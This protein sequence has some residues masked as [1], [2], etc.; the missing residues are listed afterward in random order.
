MKNPTLQ[1]MGA[2]LLVLCTGTVFAA[3]LGSGIDRSTFDAGVRPQDDLFLSATGQ[4][5]KNTPIPADK[6]AYGVFQELADRADARVR[7]ICEE[8]SQG[9][10]A[11][12]S[13][14]QKVGSYY[15]SYIDVDAIDAAG[16]SP[17]APWLA[18]IDAVTTPTE[19]VVLWGRWQGV[20]DS[21]MV[22]AVGGDPKQPTINRVMAI[23]S[24]LGL[25]DRD[26][27]LKRDPNFAKARAAYLAYMETLLQLSG[28]AQA[29]QHAKAVMALETELARVQWSVVDSQDAIKTFNPMT[30]PVLARRA[31]G[32]DWV[33]FFRA[34]ALPEIDRLSVQQPSYARAM[35]R[36]AQRTPMDTWRWYERVRLMDAQAAV[37]PKAWR[38]AAFALRGR[39]LRGQ[40][41][42]KPRWQ[43]ATDA[44]DAALGEAVGQV[45]V[46]RHFSPEAKARMQEMV[47]NLFAAFGQ[48]IDR[49]SWMTPATRQRAQEKL[50]KYT[51]KIGYPDKWRDYSA[52]DVRDGDAFGNAARA[53]RFEHERRAVQVGQ[54][55]DRSEWG[56]TPQTVNAYYD[57]SVNEIVFPAAILDTPLF[58]MGFDDAANYGA[59][60][61]TIGHEI[62]HGFDNQGSQYDGNGKLQNWWTAADRKAFDA[63]GARLVKQFNGYESLPGHK[64]N[65][66]LTLGE[67]IADL[68]GLEIAYKA[69]HLS[70]KG[71]PAPV[72]DG[73]TG[74]QRFFLAW[75]A[76]GR[77]K[78]RDARALELVTADPHAPARFRANGAVINLDAFHA[79]FGTQPGD[80]MYKPG[81]QR[82]RIW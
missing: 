70:L 81:E 64:V 18:Q 72:I 28:D 35:A 75:A 44:V 39:T 60:G 76:S 14:E 24:G 82:I 47:A 57:P 17:L 74:D 58:D 2:A 5:V 27:Y 32:L 61:A 3:S 19:L 78:M 46:A 7:K 1:R 52:L 54:P 66:R 45:Y 22:V 65:G 34:A 73:L 43:K 55:V 71:Q 63:L 25:P 4:W 48:S 33:A 79:T 38:H 11:K 40:E 30:M 50:A 23:Q 13:I 36:L 49:L 8:L 15:R 53:G 67:N 29:A 31:P 77:E 9:E 42:D 6:P 56:M 68:S 80:R 37:L 59:T 12:G 10:A 69:Y 26:Y 62:S 16:I 21:P 41:E 51:V 20:V